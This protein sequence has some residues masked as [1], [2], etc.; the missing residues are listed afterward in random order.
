[1]KAEGRSDSFSSD[2]LKRYSLGSRPNS[3][4]ILPMSVRSDLVVVV[5]VFLSL[6]ESFL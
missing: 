1:M 2:A 6:D 4:R 5:V 3:R